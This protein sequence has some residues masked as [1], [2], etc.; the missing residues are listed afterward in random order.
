MNFIKLVKIFL[1]IFCIDTLQPKLNKKTIL[2][3]KGEEGGS[4]WGADTKADGQTDGRT[5]AVFSKFFLWKKLLTLKRFQLKGNN[6]I[7]FL[8]SYFFRYLI[9]FRYLIFFGILFFS[10]S[11][12]FRYLIFFGVFLYLAGT[13]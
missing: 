6:S 4:Y 11:Y 13:F 9:V 12:F 8:V 7:F 2:K 1:F 10:E 3:P 5:D